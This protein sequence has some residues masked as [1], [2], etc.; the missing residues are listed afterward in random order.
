[1]RP[2]LTSLQSRIIFFHLFAII[3]AT[4]AVPL[5]NYLVISRSTN[6]FEART[7][8]AH[9]AAIANNLH[10]D[11][12]G[13]WRLDLPPDLN[14]LYAHE[15][16]GLSYAVT[17][18]DGRILLSSGKDSDAGFLPRRNGLIDVTRNGAELFGVARQIHGP[19]GDVWIAVA[20]NA[21]HPDVIFDDIISNY[22]SRIGWFTVAIL[23]LLLAVDIFVIRQA[24]RPVIQASAI[25]GSIHPRRSDLR[26][27]SA[28]MPSELLPLILAVN[29]ALDRLKTG[30]KLQREFTADAAHELRTP[31]AVLRARV[32]SLPDQNSVSA[33]KSDI[34]VMGHV[35]SQLLEIAELEDSPSASMSGWICRPSPPMWWA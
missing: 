22:L 14:A 4:V 23:G 31:L 33:L 13:H 10:Q 9:A 16:E 6:L 15:L 35:V 19:G 32:N 12:P 30:I 18:A 24:L 8:E 3:L 11:S 5:A 27:P 20:Q 2:R 25:A 28:G 34:D 1:M 26:L 7:L 21:Q 29:E 17:S